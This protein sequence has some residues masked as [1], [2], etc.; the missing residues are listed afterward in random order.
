MSLNIPKVGL[1]ALSAFVCYM[2]ISCTG[3]T[4]PKQLNCPPPP[5]YPCIPQLNTSAPFDTSS[6][7]NPAKEYYRTIRKVANIP[8]NHSWQFVPI[9]KDK[10]LL[11]HSDGPSFEFV[12]HQIS[13]VIFDYTDEV[14]QINPLDNHNVIFGTP[15][16]T[17][18]ELIVAVVDESEHSRDVSLYTANLDS[19]L[20]I[21]L[22]K[23]LVAVTPFQR[24]I[25]HP[26]ASPD[27]KTI[28]F[29]A[30]SPEGIKGTDLYYISKRNDGTWTAPK[31]CGDVLNSNCDDISPSFSKDGKE[32]LFS[33]FGHSG[34]GG[35][36]IYSSTVSTSTLSDGSN[37]LSFSKPINVG[38]PIN[39]PADELFPTTPST[40]FETL[41][42]TSNQENQKLF[43][44][45]VCYQKSLR[46][47]TIAT[48]DPKRGTNTRPDTKAT[49]VDSI[50]KA[51]EIEEKRLQENL[52]TT[53]TVTIDGVV[54]NENTKQ[55]IENADITVTDKQKVII[56]ETKS[57]DQGK[58]T[59]TVPINKELE[60]KAEAENVFYDVKTVKITDTNNVPPITL[61]VPI[62]LVLRINFPYDKWDNPYEYVLDSDGNETNIPWQKA[63]E[64]VG[65][66][67]I[68]YSNEFESVTIIGHTDD[69]AS[70]SYNISLGRKRANFV[71]DRLLD[72]FKA[73]LV[74]PIKIIV[75]SEGER[76]VLSK[77]EN[78]S[79]DVTRKRSRRV[80]FVK[81]TKQ[82]KWKI[83]PPKK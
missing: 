50:K 25:A 72:Y 57:D 82:Q 26:A 12:N 20:S 45:F 44:L 10:G 15:S 61:D 24:W 13:E 56:A 47:S 29:A 19:K 49:T 67:L 75:Q 4:L 78:E 68:K 51:K 54:V 38:A 27:G 11:T 40:S 43:K 64:Q 48:L 69:V 42:Y 7:K 80:E 79:I 28:V 8:S 17:Y 23:E 22:E 41:Y 35:Y 2:L 74:S 52:D 76:Q 63:I 34:Y 21:N 58:Y 36:D 70:D 81:N 60:V 16:G 3:M 71:R 32:L 6:A 1:I 65:E 33:S 46:P 83:V 73:K 77:R 5:V 31:N 30:E 66:N 53:T 59:V 62:Q 55:P 9:S 37:H 14:K 18:K 39:T